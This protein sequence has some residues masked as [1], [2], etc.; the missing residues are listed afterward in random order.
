MLN[1]IEYEVLEKVNLY[2]L[3]GAFNITEIKVPDYLIKKFPKKGQEYSLNNLYIYAK[4][5]LGRE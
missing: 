3:S 4:D 5:S 2:R 1:L